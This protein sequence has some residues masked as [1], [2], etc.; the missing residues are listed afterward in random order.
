MNTTVLDKIKNDN[1]LTKISERFP[2]KQ[3]YIVGG[4]VRDCMMDRP[5][6][7][8]DLIV[9]GIEAKDFALA[10]HEIFNSAY[11][12]LD[13]ENKIYRIVLKDSENKHN[14]EMID[15]TNPV[16]NSL[17]QDLMRRDLT[18]NSI[19]V[20]IRTGEVTDL[21]G[22]ISDIR[23]K[24]INYIVES[25]FREDPLRLLRVYRFQAALG[26]EISPEVINA[27]CKYADLIENPA[28]ER[29]LY[30]LMK[31]FEGKFSAKALI[32]MNKTWLLEKIFPIVLELKQVP[33]NTHHHL[34]L[35]HHSIEVVNQ[36]QKLYDVSPSNVREHLNRCDFG[37]F[38]R[39]AHLKLA[40]FLHDI[41][42]FST[43]TIEEDTGRHRFI[44]HDDVGAKLVKPLLKSLSC[45]NKQIEYV[46]TMIKN[47]IYPS[48]LMRE[49]D[50]NEKA[51]LKYCRKL[52][53]NVIDN[54]ILAKADRLSAL[55]EAITREV[56]EQ[57][58]KNLDIL[59]DFYFKELDKIEL[60][61]RLL[62]GKEVMEILNIR[63]GAVLGK[64]LNKMYEAQLNGELSSRDDAVRFV[65]KMFANQA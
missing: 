4:T 47:H 65:K 16:N 46:S 51:M 39:L 61:K 15:I 25:N 55:G 60:P 52:S 9:T 19:A 64:I 49:V 56:V 23:T 58:L 62:N 11:I 28:R 21:F 14:P 29:V 10:L 50:V 3:I 42:K 63:Q 32:N 40:G 38:S 8:R 7:D 26:F 18:I 45:S 57:N 53:D 17:E 34:D 6:H 2:D 35:L 44:K 22:G 27:V 43:W 12:P 48:C 13:E 37:G 20:N 5:Y 31:L 59:L 54:I 33:P 41:G 24:S 30:E 1:I 36:I